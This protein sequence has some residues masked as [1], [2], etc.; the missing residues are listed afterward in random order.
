M[1]HLVEGKDFYYDKDGYMVFT[2]HYHLEKGFCCG[3]GCLHC[4][5]DYENVPPTRRNLLL[6]DRKHAGKENSEK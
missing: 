4:P 2:E 5:F 3:H 6:K 1:Q